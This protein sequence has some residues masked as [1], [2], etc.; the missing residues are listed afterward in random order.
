ML[1][2]NGVAVLVDDNI[3]RELKQKGLDSCLRRNDIGKGR[4]NG[5]PLRYAIRPFDRLRANGNKSIFKVMHSAS[6]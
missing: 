5:S 4:P 3:Y 6:S 2:T 1:T